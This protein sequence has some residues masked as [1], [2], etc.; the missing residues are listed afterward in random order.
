[1]LELVNRA[2]LARIKGVSGVYSDLLEEAGVDT[3]KEL[4]T[5]RP[6][7]LHAKLLQTNEAKQ[8]TQ[9]PPAAA[10][11]EDWVEQAKALPKLVSY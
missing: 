5:R 11:V 6:D 9:R 4:A 2:D 3:V 7:N 8:L 10:Q 1:L